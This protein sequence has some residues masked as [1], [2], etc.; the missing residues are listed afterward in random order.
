MKSRSTSGSSAAN[1]SSSSGSR[2]G[3]AVRK[4]PTLSGPRSAPPSASAAVRTSSAWASRLRACGSSRRPDGVSSRLRALRRMS[5]CVPT[6]RSSWPTA[7]EIADCETKRR[8]A[9]AV[10][11]PASAAATKHSSWRR[12]IVDHE[13]HS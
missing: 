9:A 5:S 4:H 3:A 7:R 8:S 6:E 2:K 12:F 13:Y 11:V 10:I 1:V